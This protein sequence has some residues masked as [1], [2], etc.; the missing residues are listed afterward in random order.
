MLALGA[1]SAALA[2]PCFKATP[3]TIDMVEGGSQSIT[4]VETG[5]ERF[6]LVNP[7]GYGSESR[8]DTRTLIFTSAGGGSVITLQFTTNYAGALPQP[9]RLRDMVAANHP[10]A[11]LVAS[12][13]ASTGFGAAQSFDLFQPAGNALML[14]IR[15][16]YAAYSEGSVELTFSCNSVDFDKEKLGFAH[17]LNSFR[18]LPKDG[19]RKP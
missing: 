8:P 6:S 18:L 4:L 11:S 7:T 1:S 13:A 17:L 2:Q 19:K 14:R 9:D 15:D 12:A 5:N 3:T 10:G 16:V